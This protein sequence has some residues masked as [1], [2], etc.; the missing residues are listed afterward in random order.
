M[1][2]LDHVSSKVDYGE[3][4]GYPLPDGARKSRTLQLLMQ[5]IRCPTA[6]ANPGRCSC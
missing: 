6:Q 4:P 5:L 3:V 1:L 2:A